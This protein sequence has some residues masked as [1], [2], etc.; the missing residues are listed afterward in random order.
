MPRF[1]RSERLKGSADFKSVFQR[2]RKV[3]DGK[4]ALYVQ[5]GAEEGLRKFG[6]SVGRAFGKA[7]ERNL[8]KR[9]LREIYRVEKARFRGGYQIILIPQRGSAGCPFVE[10]RQSFLCLARRS[11]LMPRAKDPGCGASTERP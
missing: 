8:V 2:C 3:K 1:P 9:R 5:L 6:V 4:L 10:L 11:G 7:H